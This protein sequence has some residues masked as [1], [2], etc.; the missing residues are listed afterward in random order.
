MKVHEKSLIESREQ[1]VVQSEEGETTRPKSVALQFV[2]Y[3]LSVRFL[4]AA[5]NWH[6]I[7]T[8][9]DILFSF[10]VHSAEELIGETDPTKAAKWDPTSEAYKIGMEYYFKEEMITVIGDFILQD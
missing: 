5:K 8:Y 2:N 6:R 1:E 3:L 9:L 4:R 10:G 7:D